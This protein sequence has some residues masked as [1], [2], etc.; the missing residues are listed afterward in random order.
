[1]ENTIAITKVDDVSFWTL[2]KSARADESLHSGAPID[3]S[4]GS[5]NRVNGTKL[6][7]GVDDSIVWRNLSLSVD[8]GTGINHPLFKNLRKTVVANSNV[9][10]S[11]VVRGTSSEKNT[12]GELTAARGGDLGNDWARD[13]V[14]TWAEG[15][16]VTTRVA[17]E[18]GFRPG[19]DSVTGNTPEHGLSKVGDEWWSIG[20]EVT[21]DEESDN[22]KSG[23][24]TRESNRELEAIG[25]RICGNT[26]H[27]SEW[28]GS[29]NDHIVAVGLATYVASTKRLVVDTWRAEGLGIV[30]GLEEGGSISSTENGEGSS[31]RLT[32]G[33]VDVAAIKA[34]HRC[35]RACTDERF[36]LPETHTSSHRD[37][38]DTAIKKMHRVRN[39]R[40]RS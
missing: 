8:G 16:L 9:N 27:A 26:N 21:V 19:N 11:K 20:L 14:S 13:W 36:G 5:V 3:S 34:N 10:G 6:F 4:S 7:N 1:M 35:S 39:I 12:V 37:G 32:V 17:V 33:Q 18:S 38:M 40:R 22:F 2:G 24:G 25:R 15:D 29:P 23:L 31:H 30:G 28:L